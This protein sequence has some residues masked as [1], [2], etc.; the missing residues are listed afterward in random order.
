M[1]SILAI[2]VSPPCFAVGHVC[3]R[4]VRDWQPDWIG[5]P[6][7]M[8]YQKCMA[9]SIRIEEWAGVYIM[10]YPVQDDRGEDA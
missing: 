2:V 8:A 3:S 5:M 7:A 10:W 4:L 6:L 1:R 9:A